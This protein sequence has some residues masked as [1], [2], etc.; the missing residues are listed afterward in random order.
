[1]TANMGTPGNPEGLP[2]WTAK[3]LLAHRLR[4]GMQNKGRRYGTVFRRQLRNISFPSVADAPEELQTALGQVQERVDEISPLAF[5]VFDEPPHDDC[6][7]GFMV[8]NLLDGMRGGDVKCEEPFGDFVPD[9]A[10]YREGASAPHAVIEVVHTNSPS[11]RKRGFYE[12]RRIA[13]FAL[14]VGGEDNIRATVGRTAVRVFALSNAPCGRDIREQIGAIDKYIADKFNSGEHPFVG[15]KAYRSGAQEYII[16]T[17]DPND[18]QEWH[19]GEPE[20]LGFCPTPVHWDSPP[21][22]TPI[23][24]RSLSKR[25]F[26]AYMV[27]SIERMAS[28]IHEERAGAPEKMAFLTLGSYSQDLLDAVHVPD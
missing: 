21:M 18:E 23:E 1:M 3:G 26:L 27:T 20:V 7:G 15:I 11:E 16:G 25:I 4:R 17:C 19:Y 13:A 24:V 10:L 22:I 28:F 2:H 12:A 5:A 9:I 14:H 8:V 6:A